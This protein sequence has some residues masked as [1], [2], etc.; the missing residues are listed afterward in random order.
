MV[1]YIGQR[2]CGYWKP[3]YFPKPHLSLNKVRAIGC[4]SVLALVSERSTAPG[5]SHEEAWPD[6]R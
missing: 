3:G 5:F 4:R 1:S 6:V 2:F